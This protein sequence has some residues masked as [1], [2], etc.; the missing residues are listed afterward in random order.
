MRNKCPGSGVKVVEG[1][2]VAF[3][4]ICPTCNVPFQVSKHGRLRV[5]SS[6]SKTDELYE[7]RM[8]QRRATEAPNTLSE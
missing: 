1:W 2:A 5:H 8:E 7:R 4:V 6:Y 3:Q